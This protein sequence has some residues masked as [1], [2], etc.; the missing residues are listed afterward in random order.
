MKFLTK[1]SIHLKQFTPAAVN[2]Q[3][4]NTTLLL[5]HLISYIIQIERNEYIAT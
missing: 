4:K 2:V 3:K 1:T 5:I